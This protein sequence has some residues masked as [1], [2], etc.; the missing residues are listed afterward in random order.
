MKHVTEAA[1]NS[2]LWL[3]LY[4]HYLISCSRVHSGKHSYCSF[5][6]NFELQRMQNVVVVMSCSR[7]ANLP[8]RTIRKH[9]SMITERKEKKRKV[10]DS[11]LAVIDCLSSKK[12]LRQ[13]LLKNQMSS[14]IGHHLNLTRLQM[15][16][17]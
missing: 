12:R 1:K 3:S 14:S 16:V 4:Y 7:R 13:H 11:G 2:V 17:S 15:L 5:Q 8:L 10:K 6:L 9:Y